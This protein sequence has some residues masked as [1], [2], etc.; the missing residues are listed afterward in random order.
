MQRLTALVDNEDRKLGMLDERVSRAAEHGLAPRC[1][2]EAANHQ[3]VG[4]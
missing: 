2:A 1:V 4:V 3:Q